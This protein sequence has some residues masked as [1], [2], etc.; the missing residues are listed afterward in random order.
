[1]NRHMRCIEISLL[2]SIVFIDFL[3]EPTHEMYWNTVADFGVGKYRRLNRHMRCIEINCI[4]LYLSSPILLNRHMRCI[5]I[6]FWVVFLFMVYLL[7]RHMRCI[8]ICFSGW[9]DKVYASIEPT[10]EMYWNPPFLKGGF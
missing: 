8:E 3:I 6:L 5:E 10:H 1:M 7:N 9:E 2:Y 4:D